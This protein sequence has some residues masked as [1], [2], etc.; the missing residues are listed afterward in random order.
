M[1]MKNLV[2]GIGIF[3]VFALVL[4]QGLETFYPT[5]MYEDYCSF[6]SGPV[7]I[8]KPVECLNVPALQ[9]KADACWQSKGEFVY[10]YDANGCPVDGYCDA[11]RIDYEAALDVHSNRV[12]IISVIIGI[13]VFVVGLFLLATEPVGSA[14]MASGIWSIFYGVVK[15]WRNFSNSWRFLLL[16]VLLIV[17]IWVALRFNSKR[18]MGFFG[19]RHR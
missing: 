13:L 2:L 3:I 7:A 10:E 8:G 9:T 5:P 4:F 14:L 19:R 11:C 16:F 17:L 1:K 15:N 12:F 18:K 6:R